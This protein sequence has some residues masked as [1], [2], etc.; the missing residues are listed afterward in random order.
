MA[1]GLA[2]CGRGE[3]AYSRQRAQ[4]RIDAEGAQRRAE[5]DRR[6][7]ALAIGFRIEE[8]TA[9]ARQRDFFL[10]LGLLLR[11]R[12]PALVDV[13]AVVQQIIAAAEI[14]RRA[15]GP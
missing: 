1:W 5:E 3:G 15:Q 7:M 14:R 2:G 13:E 10:E 12:R 9:G 6:H 4:Q 11:V 8:R